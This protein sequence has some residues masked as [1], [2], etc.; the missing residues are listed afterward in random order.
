[1]ND[2]SVLAQPI[3]RFAI[4]QIALKIRNIVGLSDSYYFPIIP[5]IEFI[6]P[7]IYKDFYVDIICTNNMPQNYAEA[8]PQLNIMRVR[9]DVYENAYKN[10][11]RDRFTLAHEV[12]HFILHNENRVALARTE[13]Q[14]SIP[15][16]MKPEWQAN[17]FAAEL[18]IPA[19]LVKNANTEFIAKACKVSNQVATIQ[20]KFI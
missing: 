3:S 5:F 10:I 16:Y 12:G 20:K 11:G 7:K 19:H 9:E 18:L 14:H 6:M 4:R 15:A 8:L 1:M 17:T 2:D 13:N